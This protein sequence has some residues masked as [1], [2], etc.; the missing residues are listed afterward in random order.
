[1]RETGRGQ[2]DRGRS[3]Q[4]AQF[5]EAGPC[6]RDRLGSA[7]EQGGEL[8]EE[9]EPDLAGEDSRLEHLERHWGF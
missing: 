7:P 2:P 1:M 4:K 3:V 5:E 8:S 6:T 9:A